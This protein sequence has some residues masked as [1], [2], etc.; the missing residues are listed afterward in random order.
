MLKE[1]IAVAALAVN[2]TP[3]PAQAGTGNELVSLCETESYACLEYI[4]G[5]V[6]TLIYSKISFSKASKFCIPDGVTHGQARSIILKGFNNS[7]QIL[8]NQAPYLIHAVMIAAFPCE[9][10]ND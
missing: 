1:L 7:P 4:S 6:E 8:H 9:A 10:K 5:V 3:Q 2:M